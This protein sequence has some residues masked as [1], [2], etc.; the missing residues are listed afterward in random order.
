MFL[1][2]LRM[3]TFLVQNLFVPWLELFQAKTM[4]WVMISLEELSILPQRQMAWFRYWVWLMSS[5]FS[6]FYLFLCE[7]NEGAK[8]KGEILVFPRTIVKRMK[9]RGVLTEKNANDPENVGERS[10]LSSDRKMLQESSE[11]ESDTYGEIGL[12]KSEAIFHWRNLCYEV[13]IKAETRRILNNVDGWVK[14]GTLTA[15]MGASG[16]GKTTLLDC[17]AE[18]V[19]MGVITGDILVNGIPRDKSFPRS[20]GYCQ[21]QDLHLKTATVR[22]SL[23]FSA[24]LRQPAEVSIE[25]KNRYVEEVIKILE[26]EKYADAVVGV[27]GEGSER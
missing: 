24:Y 19:T 10:D 6:L 13:Q 22:E 18:R 11:E 2:V 3:Q 25:E 12:S 8:Q 20:I 14:P 21:Q 26:M 9:K 16:A 23:R 4:F 5:S 17:L 1:V 7:Y 15:L 27:A